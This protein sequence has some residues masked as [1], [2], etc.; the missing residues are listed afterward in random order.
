MKNATRTAGV[1][2]AL[3]MAAV[4]VGNIGAALAAPASHCSQV[5]FA[6]QAAC[7]KRNSQDACER[8]IGPRMS[9]CLKTGC[10]SNARGK[11]CG[12]VRL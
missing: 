1:V 11:R 7:M 3:A 4:S 12:L 8:L 5:Y 6:A 2:V 9:A 10:W